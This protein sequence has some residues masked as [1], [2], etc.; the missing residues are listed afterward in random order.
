M[1][2]KRHTYDFLNEQDSTI[3]PRDESLSNKTQKRGKEV[4]L[5][6]DNV[7]F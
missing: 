4:I 3:G 1:R 5:S 6:Q 2:L 7:L